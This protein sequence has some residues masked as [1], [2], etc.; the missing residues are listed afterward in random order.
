MK[1]VVGNGISQCERMMLGFFPQ[2]RA[3]I[4]EE[5]DAVWAM[6]KTPKE[7][8]DAAHGHPHNED[9]SEM[10]DKDVAKKSGG[11]DHEHGDHAEGWSQMTTFFAASTGLLFVLLIVSVLVKRKEVAA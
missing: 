9:G 4:D 2:I 6:S 7:A 5:L 1:D 8:L 3:V 11:H 10:S